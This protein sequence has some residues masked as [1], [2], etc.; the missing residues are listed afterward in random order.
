MPLKWPSRPKCDANA[1]GRLINSVAHRPEPDSHAAPAIFHIAAIDLSWVT[2][3]DAGLETKGETR[4]PL[5]GQQV[6]IG[7]S[8][9]SFTCE[10]RLGLSGASAKYGWWVVTVCPAT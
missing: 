2:L 1:G 6:Q 9:K 3:D 10:K 8:V 5:L 4:I 7:G